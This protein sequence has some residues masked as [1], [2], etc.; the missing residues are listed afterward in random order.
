MPIHFVFRL[1]KIT[2]K[3]NNDLELNNNE[4][5]KALL[6]YTVQSVPLNELLETRVWP[7]FGLRVC[8]ELYM[9][10]LLI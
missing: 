3:K 8:G 2:F 1:Y 4:T 6:G 7:V 9:P 5:K 10:S